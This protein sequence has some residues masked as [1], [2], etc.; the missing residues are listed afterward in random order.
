MKQN[1]T[2]VLELED[3]RHEV[4]LAMTLWVDITFLQQNVYRLTSL[5][6]ERDLFSHKSAA[7]KHMLKGQMIVLPD[8]KSVEDEHNTISSEGNGG[9]QIVN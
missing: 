9:S 3:H 2:N 7:G 5:L 1:L 6:F 8:N 4:L